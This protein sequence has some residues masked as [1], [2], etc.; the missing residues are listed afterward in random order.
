[1]QEWF[2]RQGKRTRSGSRKRSLWE[3][4]WS[5]ANR[6]DSGSYPSSGSLF[7]SH[8]WKGLMFHKNNSF[9]ENLR[10]ASSPRWSCHWW[11]WQECASL[12]DS[13]SFSEPEKWDLKAKGI[14]LG[15]KQWKREQWGTKTWRQ[16]YS[17]P[18]FWRTN[19]SPALGE[20]VEKK[21]GKWGGWA[22]IALFPIESNRDLVL[23][24]FWD[25][26]FSGCATIRSGNLG[27]DVQ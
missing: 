19:K 15:R 24:K 1:M 12:P 20:N 10:W 26:W 21:S 3:T 25:S 5:G 6:P 18:L 27:R 13:R 11:D 2:F 8:A 22:E 4:S 14:V 16:V 17:A 7:G 23:R 9:S